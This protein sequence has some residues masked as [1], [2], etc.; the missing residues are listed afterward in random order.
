[1]NKIT[2]NV[3]C[4]LLFKFISCIVARQKGC[5]N[6]D[7]LVETLASQVYIL[8][9]IS[10]ISIF[11]IFPGIFKTFQ[12]FYPVLLFFSMN[13]DFTFSIAT[14]FSSLT[15]SWNL[16][17]ILFIYYIDFCMFYLYFSKIFIA[18]SLSFFNKMK[19][20]FVN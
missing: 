13:L 6:S 8:L 11:S 2:E 3:R 5:R 12:I 9:T 18:F 19:N 14:V 15:C 10:L 20:I 4:C 7:S 1:M 16:K 17:I